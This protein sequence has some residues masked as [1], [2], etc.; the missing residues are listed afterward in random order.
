M[1]S[2]PELGRSVPPA[3]DPAPHLQPSHEVAARLQ[4]D[5]DQGLAADEVPPRRARHGSNALAAAAPRSV[6]SRL[7]APFKD[8]MI[9]VLLAAALLSGLIG[10]VADT[11]AILVIVLLNAALSISQEWQADRAL[12]ALQRLAAPRAQVRRDGQDQAIDSHE[13][14]PGDVVHLEAG[15]LVPADLR[16]HAVAQLR[17][18]ESALTGESLTVDKHSAP[19]PAAEHALGD[20][21][22]I[23]FKGTL[24]THGRATGLVVATGA[25]TEIGRIAAML[26]ASGDRT[27]PLQRRLAAF[28]Q[29]LSVVVLVICAVVFGVGLLRGEELLLMALTSISLA[30][31]AIP[32]A[33]P[34]VATVLLALGARK[35]V[36]VKALVR[37]LPA[38]ES[39]GSVTTICSDKTG[40]LTL[41]RMTVSTH[42]AANDGAA[43]LLWRAGLLCNDAAPSPQG[44]RGD[45]TETA[46]AERAES[47]G[48]D[49]VAE[50]AAWPRRHEWPF[51]A[52]RKRMST[53]H[54]APDGWVAC[55]KGAPE[56]VLPR[57]TSAW[58][59]DG[60]QPID[61][62][63]WQATV[64]GLAAQGLRVLALAQREGSIDRLDAMRALD[65]DQAERELV[66]LG[67]VGLID[68]PRPEARDAVAECHS[69][70]V[71]VVMITGDHPQTALAIASQLGI[72]DAVE[73]D[74]AA[75]AGTTGAARQ[76][77]SG[78]ELARLD[79]H[80][81]AAM[82]SD[83]RVYA[84]MDPAQKIRIVQALQS[85]GELVAMTG[86]GVNDAPAL[87]AADIGVAMGQGGT[88]VAREAAGLVL[89]DDN[90][91][92]I[93]AAVREGRR[94][95]DNIRKFIRYAMTGNSAEIWVLFLAPLV[96]LPI[97]L[98]P[99]HILWINL[100]T[101]GL[102]GLALAA[103][104]GERGLMRRPPRP[105][106]ESVFAHG[107]WQH[108]LLVGILI[109]GLCLGVQA[110]ALET[111]HAHWQ[112]M[113]FTVLTLAQMAHLMAIRS[114]GQSIISLGLRSNRPLLGAVALTFALQMAVIYV[115]VLQPIFRTEALSGAEL[116]LCLACAALVTAAVEAEKAWRRRA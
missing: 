43:A 78:P 33:L 109:A 92:T 85:R 12:A 104:P 87:K 108:A 39:L 37:R 8:F 57:C 98:L 89:L 15:N 25:A 52:D 24:V 63:A 66:F 6:A 30:V 53:L 113:V 27:T 13:L 86:D 93:V 16:L 36:L 50:R 82:V 94:I 95:F 91:A 4:V 47:A 48:L 68:P 9:L 110:W 102:P 46:V 114:E 35:L 115:P 40:T 116:A 70:G 14:V 88:D 62:A 58:G 96:G 19:L 44:W 3:W 60:A 71:R 77:I 49:A 29:R 74:E 69:A 28:G 84:R 106:T 61:I 21:R 7:I 65:A 56:S 59:A 103:E 111:G 38:V 22:N 90:F 42:Q 32:E 34:A 55:V 81:L 73:A 23:A 64:Q 31:A 26:D 17:I 79:D 11:V 51:D 107:L 72:V 41:N 105:P 20:L 1:T 112:T 18:D 80:A 2:Q 75:D 97:P 5:P 45:P 54:V 99:I 67:L 76:V 101:D 10:E 100:V 83:V